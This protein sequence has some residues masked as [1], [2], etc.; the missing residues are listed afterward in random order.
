MKAPA[1]AQW[2]ALSARQAWILTVGAIALE[3]PVRWIV[4]PDVSVLAPGNPWFSLP[5]RIGIEA[6]MIL[7]FVGAALAAGAPLDA[8]GI[9]LRRWTRWEWGALA[10][11]GGVELVV[12]VSLVG[13]RWPRI[14]A[15]GLMGEGLAWAFGEF[16]FGFNQETGFRGMMMSGLLR[17]GGW[18]PAFAVNTALFSLGPLH[19]PGLLEWLGRSPGA[20]AG[21]SAGVIVCGLAS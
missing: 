3:I 10:V 17:I 12:V 16:L 18:K 8:V 20:A 2:S 9:P 5:L 1:S 13:H 11:V 7:A 6:G 14:W 4:R 21:Y 15:A 19:G